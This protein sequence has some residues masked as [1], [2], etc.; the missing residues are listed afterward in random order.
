MLSRL[1]LLKNKMC[2]GHGCFMCPYQPKHSQNSSIIRSEVI[3]VC[4]DEELQV[5]NEEL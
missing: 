5:I 2:C 4:N 3:K 1:L